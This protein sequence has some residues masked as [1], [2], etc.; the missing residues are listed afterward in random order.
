MQNATGKITEFFSVGAQVT[1]DLQSADGDVQRIAGKVAAVNEI[2]I[3]LDHA[4]TEQTFYVWS[5]IRMVRK[6]N[7]Q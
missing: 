7:Q 6:V 4:P 3:L 5:S 2:G 1:L